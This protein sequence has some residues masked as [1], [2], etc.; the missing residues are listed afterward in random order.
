MSRIGRLPIKIAE[1]VNFEITGRNIK[2][3]GPKGELALELPR[4]IKIEREESTVF[5]KRI[6]DE[7]NSRA[8]HGLWRVLIDNSI[9][10][11]SKGW[12]R[13]LD[14][15]GVGFRAEVQGKKLILNVGFSHP[16]EIEA[17]EGIEITT[18]KNTI[19]V[20]GIDKQKVGQV[21][22][23]IR[24]VKPVEPYKGKGIKYIDEVPR[25]KLGKAAKAA[26]AK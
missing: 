20:S 1:G 21:A 23:N 6:N 3:T 24:R 15:K 9:V 26:G 18:I 14:F 22:A 7:K 16:V 10:G 13:K 19:T 5:V 4:E 17:P 8:L 11:V 25:R 2:V 12:D